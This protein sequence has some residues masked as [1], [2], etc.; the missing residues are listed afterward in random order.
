MK[1]AWQAHATP[2]PGRSLGCT[3]FLTIRGDY[4]GD[5]FSAMSVTDPEGGMHAM[6]AGLLPDH[7]FAPRPPAAGLPL[8]DWRAQTTAL[9]EKHADEIAAVIVEP[10]LQGAGGMHVYDP[11]AIQLL[12]ELARRNGALVIFDEIATG[13]WR[14][15][16]AWAADRCGVVPD[17]LCV[18]KALTGGYLSLAAGMTTAEGAGRV[19]A[20][21][22]GAMMHGPTFMANP[23]AC[24]VA[25]ASLELLDTYDSEQ[26]ISEIET[27]LREGLAPAADL[28]CVVDVRVLGGV[29]VVQLDRPVDV[30]AVTRAAL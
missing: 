17:I 7:V 22:A 4:H 26:R 2:G 21:P 20:S 16:A 14:T 25:S 10:V 30:A 24:A 1:M 8:D 12:V 9:Y 11:V 6:Y 28:P 15:G 13:F 5:T 23:L 27:A 3:K 19:D 29:G 18:G